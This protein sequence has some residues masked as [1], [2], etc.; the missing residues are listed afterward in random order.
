MSKEFIDNITKEL[1]NFQMPSIAT[2]ICGIDMTGPHIFTVSNEYSTC[3][4]NCNDSVGFASVGSGSRHAESQF[5]LAS[6][7]RSSPLPETLLLTYSSKKRSEIAPGVGKG[8]DMFVIGPQLGSFA[9]LSGP[10]AIIDIQKLDEIDKRVE[11][12]AKKSLIKAKNEAN[13]Y[14]EEIYKKRAAETQQPAKA[15][16]GVQPP[17]NGTAVSV[18]FK[19]KPAA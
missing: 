4:V 1:V 5:M 14:V 3:R 9:M 16:D 15:V 19:E 12:R 6:H 7:S 17:D 18:D 11:I 13:E 8:T 2:I 10:K